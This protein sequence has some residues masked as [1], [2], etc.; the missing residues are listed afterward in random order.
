[1]NYR[2]VLIENDEGFSV[3]YPALKGC[4]S[5]GKTREEAIGNIRDAIRECRDSEE[6]EKAMFHITEEVVT[7]ECGEK[8]R[9]SHN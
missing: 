5:Q 4:H 6:A 8:H 3:S 2:G 7:V 1:M 9:M